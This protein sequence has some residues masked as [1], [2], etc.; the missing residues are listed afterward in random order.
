MGFPE[1]YTAKGSP[2]EQ[3]NA[4]Q[5]E[6]KALLTPPQHA[7][8]HTCNMLGPEHNGNHNGVAICLFCLL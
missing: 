1:S 2:S 6:D 5:W 3:N 4:S 7:F 8:E